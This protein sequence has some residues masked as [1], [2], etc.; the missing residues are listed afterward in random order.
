MSDY[1]YIEAPS[2]E[3]YDNEK[4]IFLAGTI[5][6]AWDW[7]NFA[8]K[9]LAGFGTVVNPRRATYGGLAAGVNQDL[10]QIRWEHEQL[11]NVPVI[12]FWFSQETVA[13]ITLFEYGYWLARGDKT[14]VVGIDPLYPRLRDVVMQTKLANETLFA[15]IKFSLDDTINEAIKELE[16]VEDL[17][18]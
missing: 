5:S 18:F 13:P 4:A 15:S 10:E 2:K 16:K 1:K 14:L 12:M 8:A 7:Q 9:N 11:Q 6:G 17:P 3:N